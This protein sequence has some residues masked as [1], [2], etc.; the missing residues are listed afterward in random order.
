MI[1]QKKSNCM[2]NARGFEHTPVISVDFTSCPWFCHQTFYVSK[3]SEVQGNYIY[4]YV[5]VIDVLAMNSSGVALDVSIIVPSWVDS[6]SI[7]AF[8]GCFRSS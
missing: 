7:C 6:C 4:I 1:Y 3:G 2:M 5:S 8:A